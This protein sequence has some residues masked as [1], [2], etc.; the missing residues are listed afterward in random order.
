LATTFGKTS[1]GASVSALDINVKWVSK[2]VLPVAGKI[3]KL[4]AYVDGN[5]SGVGAQVAKG[6]IYT[7][8]AGTPSALVRTGHEVSIADGQ[9]AA[10]VD[11]WFADPV[12]VPAATYWLGL[13]GGANTL[14]LQSYYD[15]V[16]GA[17]EWG[18]D[19][20]FDDPSPTWGTNNA[21]EDKE[22]S[23]Y[24]TLLEATINPDYRSFPR[25]A[26]RK[27]SV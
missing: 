18:T 23:I 5:G 17:E 13:I 16:V 3:C 25:R 19:N 1:I 12:I 8:A 27:V 2:F 10:W 21:N 20:Y 6:I 4:T 15:A 26:L 24:A 11:F 22:H 7:D 9:A 14:T